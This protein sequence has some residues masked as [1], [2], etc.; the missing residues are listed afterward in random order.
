MFVLRVFGKEKI[1]QNSLIASTVHQ[2][3]VQVKS[4]LYE[5]TP[6]FAGHQ[7]H[8]GMG[9]YCAQLHHC[10]SKVEPR[11]ISNQS[12]KLQRI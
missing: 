11:S 1:M 5:N 2:F 3:A 8:C 7:F 10:Q 12:V 9:D 4:A 6:A